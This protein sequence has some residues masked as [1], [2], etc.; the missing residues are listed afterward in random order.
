M[1]KPEINL[2]HSPSCERN[3]DPILMVL[4][5]YLDQGKGRFLEIGHGTGQHALYFARSLSHLDYTAADQRPYH[6]HLQQ[7][8]EMEKSSPNLHGPYNFL[9]TPQGI[10]HNLPQSTYNFIFS[11]N[12]LHIMTA[13][14]AEVFINEVPSLLEDKGLLFI[15]GPFKIDGHFTSESN[16]EF[17]HNLKSRN[18]EMGIRDFESIR[19]ELKNQGV[20]LLEKIHMPANNFMLIF[21]KI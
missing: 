2:A 21:E 9:V 1:T 16:G 10:S 5:K 7:R 8:M 4:K 15:Y 20:E 12:T 13:T 18:P 19:D 17:D 6:L 3:K 11:A 14:E